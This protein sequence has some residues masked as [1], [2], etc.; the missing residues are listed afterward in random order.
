MELFLRQS[1][2]VHSVSLSLGSLYPCSTVGV[3]EYLCAVRVFI[4]RIILTRVGC[5][6][7]N[8][9]MDLSF[10]VKSGGTGKETLEFRDGRNAVASLLLWRSAVFVAERQPFP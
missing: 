2:F 10:Q 4:D 1:V 9:F 5:V 3:K 8:L 6:R 7:V